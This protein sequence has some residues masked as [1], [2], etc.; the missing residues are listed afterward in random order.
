MDL[1]DALF[2]QCLQAHLV[3]ALQKGVVTVWDPLV[4]VVLE[5]TIVAVQ[6]LVLCQGSDVLKPQ[7]NV[8]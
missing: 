3:R 1:G 7:V 2:I 8:L 6:G 5:A 4:V